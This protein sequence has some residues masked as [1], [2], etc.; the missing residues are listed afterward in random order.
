MDVLKGIATLLGV[1]VR[2]RASL[3]AENLADKSELPKKLENWQVLWANSA[4][5]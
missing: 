4:K 1:L 3:A 5:R 2:S